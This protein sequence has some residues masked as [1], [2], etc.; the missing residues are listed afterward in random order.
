MG[1][2]HAAGQQVLRFGR[3]EH[4]AVVAVFAGVLFKH[5]GQRPRREAQFVERHIDG[6]VEGV[7]H[8]VLALVHHPAR[9]AAVVEQLGRGEVAARRMADDELPFSR[10]PRTDEFSIA[11][12]A[13]RYHRRSARERM[14]EHVG[15]TA[16]QPGVPIAH[17][18]PDRHHLRPP[19]AD[20][21]GHRARRAGGDRHADAG[22]VAEREAWLVR[23]C[24]LERGLQIE[25]REDVGVAV[26]H[27]E[28]ETTAALHSG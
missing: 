23:P 27:G 16:E 4:P 6:Q 18:A 21:D 2:G 14:A 10:Q 1:E 15:D 7:E 26:H 17:A 25:R 8:Q 13:I 5:V 3:I 9:A 12:G 11:R 20:C 24:A 22:E 19:E 28:G